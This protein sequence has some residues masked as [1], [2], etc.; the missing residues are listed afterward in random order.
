MVSALFLISKIHTI[1]N[2]EI[3]A[4]YNKNK[5]WLECMNFILP[6]KTWSLEIHIRHLFITS[7]YFSLINLFF[8]FSKQIKFLFLQYI[9]RAIQSKKDYNTANVWYIDVI[10]YNSHKIWNNILMILTI[11]PSMPSKFLQTVKK[12][13]LKFL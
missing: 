7:N 8:M 9:R 4:I 11:N 2:Q 1:F 13:I 6:R 3:F 5:T 10:G 12:F